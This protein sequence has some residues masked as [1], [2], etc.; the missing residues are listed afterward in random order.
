MRSQNDTYCKR[1]IQTLQK[2]MRIGWP[3]LTVKLAGFG[4]A[5]FIKFCL[6]KK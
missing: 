5:L 1:T 6:H 2:K 4:F 3:S